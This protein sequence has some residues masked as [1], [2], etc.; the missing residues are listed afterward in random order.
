MKVLK[1]SFMLLLLVGVAAAQTAS[2]PADAP[3]VKVIKAR[4]RK[5]SR[6]NPKLDQDPLRVTQA[7]ADRERVMK[8]A[9]YENR[10]RVEAKL[11][12]INLPLR[13]GVPPAEYSG[14]RTSE[15]TYEA[16]ISNTGAKK[17]REIEWEYV[18]TDAETGRESGRHQFT[19]KVN[20]SPG[21]SKTVY[22]T[23]VYTPASV[24]HVSKSG[25]KE[26]LD[27]FSES[28]IIRRIEYMDGSVW[29]RPSR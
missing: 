3:G 6:I 25:K 13:A 20:L 7:V 21:K 1:L 8:D 17:I 10:I 5:A 11:E 18:F 24:V 28:V 22:G 19:S 15:Y 29:E 14:P 26:T 27:Q 9:L 12:P 4:W 16:R 2:P 23:S